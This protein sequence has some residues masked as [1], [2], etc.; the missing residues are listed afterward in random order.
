MKKQLLASIISA[1]ILSACGGGS[2]GVSTPVAVTPP[3]TCIA[4]QVLTNG[5]CVTPAP[6]V[7]PAKLQT[8]VPTPT[9][10]AGSE[11]LAAF[12]EFNGFRK[13]MGLGLVAQNL[14]LDTAAKNHANYIGLN[15]ILGHVE[16]PLKS[17][18]TGVYPLDRQRFAGY[19]GDG[20]YGAGEVIGTMGTGKISIRQLVNTM[21]H[22]EGI[23]AQQISDIGLGFTAA[24]FKPLVVNTG[25]TK[26]LNNASDFVTT[27]PVDTQTDLPLTMQAETPNQFSDLNATNNDYATKTSSPISIY[28]AERTLLSVTTFKVVEDGQTSALDA[29][30]VTRSSDENKMI[31]D[32]TVFLVGK[33]PFKANTKYNV[34]F[35]GNVNGVALVKN[36]SFTTGT[37]LNLGGG[38]NK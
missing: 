11:E 14:N 15:Q 26:I 4:P 36:W 16:D 1:V 8:T 20:L 25:I 33:A 37:S 5:P 24:W 13:M 35:T 17:G 2:G 29:R 21:Y 12:N 34:S 30:L 10:L 32:N 31:G 23:F 9:Y 28:S 18:Y 22:Q 7:T 27:Y 6:T 19:T 3:V 38:A